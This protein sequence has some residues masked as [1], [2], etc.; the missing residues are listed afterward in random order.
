MLPK[1]KRL[2]LKK[3]FTWVALGKRY[4]NNLVKIFFR[5]GDNGEPRIGIATSKSVFKKAVDRNRARRLLSKGFEGL[6]DTLPQK[7]NIVAMP[8]EEISKSD[9]KQV[10][11]ALKDILRRL[12]YEKDNC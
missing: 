5:F 10:E 12:C 6:Y 8:Q 11:Q 7:I 3:D 4:S 2:N 9:S 1:S